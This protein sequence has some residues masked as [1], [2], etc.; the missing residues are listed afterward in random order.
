MKRVEIYEVINGTQQKVGDIILD[1]L[2][3]LVAT[4]GAGEQILNSFS[5]DG[6]RLITK[7]EP[8]LFLESLNRRYRSPYL[9]VTTPIVDDSSSDLSGQESSA[10]VNP[11]NLNEIPAKE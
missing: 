8:E 9:R 4:S 7:H 1:D 3:R 11:T 5:D 6:R 2:G 10:A